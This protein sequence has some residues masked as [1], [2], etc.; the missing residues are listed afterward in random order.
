MANPYRKTVPVRIFAVDPFSVADQTN[1]V[2]DG[3][4]ANPTWTIKAPVPGYACMTNRTSE[5]RHMC[6]FRPDMGNA[7]INGLNL[8]RGAPVNYG[9]YLTFDPS[10]LYVFDA[11]A[12]EPIEF[13][14]AA[15]SSTTA[16]LV[17]PTTLSSDWAQY[18]AAG[19]YIGTQRIDN[20]GGFSHNNIPG[21]VLGSSKTKV[22]ISGILTPKKNPTPPD[23]LDTRQTITNSGYAADLIRSEPR[24]G[25]VATKLVADLRIND[26]WESDN[27]LRSRPST[28]RP[29]AV[30]YWYEAKITPMPPQVANEALEVV[31]SNPADTWDN[32]T[33]GVNVITSESTALADKR[34]LEAMIAFET[35]WGARAVNATRVGVD[36]TSW[37]T[38]SF[39]LDTTYVGLSHEM[40]DKV[41]KW[42]GAWREIHAEFS[43]RGTGTQGDV[44]RRDMLWEEFK[45]L[46]PNTNLTKEQFLANVGAYMPDSLAGKEAGSSSWWD[47]VKKTVSWA[48]ERAGDLLDNDTVQAGLVGAGA[49][50]LVNEKYRPFLWAGAGLLLLSVLK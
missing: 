20:Y 41:Q 33:G 23:L 24:I 25:E 44:D 35:T 22:H 31:L 10:P 7:L 32:P 16:P 36:A 40:W 50:G 12:A 26:R 4:S 27:Q 13:K 19:Q 2:V 9:A 30:V 18:R 11:V 49:V 38:M 14:V 48:G 8:G 34:A 45:R 29:G 37:P 28:G 46:N 5:Y 47:T 43:V 39:P 42:M 17:V 21:A 3:M 6:L 1:G 15:E